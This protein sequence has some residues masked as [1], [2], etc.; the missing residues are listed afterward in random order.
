M[1]PHPGIGASI[2]QWS[3]R[4]P[5]STSGIAH[6]S[7]TVRPIHRGIGRMIHV[8]R[9]PGGTHRRR[10]AGISIIR[11]AAHRG[12]IGPAPRTA[13]RPG[14]CRRGMNHWSVV[15]N[16]RMLRGAHVRHGCGSG[17]RRGTALLVVLCRRHYGQAEQKDKSENRISM[18]SEWLHRP[19]S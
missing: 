3:I 16:R 18:I 4:I 10:P 9:V 5:Q 1:A 12:V 14:V 19:N 6:V 8:S 7:G 17:W 13:I 15:A 2:P 11:S